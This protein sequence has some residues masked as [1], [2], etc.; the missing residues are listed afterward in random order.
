MHILLNLP[1][2]LNLVGEFFSVMGARRKFGG[3]KYLICRGEE[4]KEKEKEENIWRRKVFGPQRWR[5]TEKVKEENIRSAKAKK[6][7]EEKE[8]ILSEKENVTRAE[9]DTYRHCEDRARTLDSE[10][11]MAVFSDH[12]ITWTD[13]CPSS[14]FF[15]LSRLCFCHVVEHEILI[16]IVMEVSTLNLLSISK[17]NWCG[18]FFQINHMWNNLIGHR[19]TLMVKKVWPIKNTSTRQ[20]NGKGFPPLG[21]TSFA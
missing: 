15:S 11:A 4:K 17:L 3:G 8:E 13:V 5:K 2:S 10:F 7:E 12:K 16:L 1:R 9:R 19:K 14:Y 18:G 20:V 6:M 21:T